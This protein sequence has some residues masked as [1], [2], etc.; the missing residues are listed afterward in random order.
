MHV[1]IL[2]AGLGTRLRPLSKRVPKP[3]IDICGKSLISKIIGTFKQIGLRDFTIIIGYESQSIR[4]EIQKMNDIN[5][6]FVNQDVQ[7]GMAEALFLCL[8]F[9]IEKDGIIPDFFLTASDVL[10]SP[11]R[12]KLMHD[13]FNSTHSDCIL[14][15]MK[16]YDEEIARGHGNVAIKKE[17]NK[18]P[19]LFTKNIRLITDIIE[20]PQPIQILSN[21]YSLPLYIFKHKIYE[22]L[23]NI[24]ISIRGEK[25]L[26]DA[27]KSIIK[28]QGSVY[29]INIIDE[30]ISQENIGKYHLT[31]LNDIKLM[32]FRFLRG[33]KIENALDTYPTILEPINLESDVSINEDVL[34]GP[35]VII[36]QNTLISNNCEISNSIIYESCNINPFCILNGCIV[37][38]DTQIPE[39][40]RIINK[41]I[42]F[43]DNKKLQLIDLL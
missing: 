15:L 7:G 39:G 23:K 13:L 1:I 14:S 17:K 33:I 21:Y 31:Y 20:K 40:M 24:K 2:A 18:T 12:L 32:N 29:G 42:Y 26:Q 25:E 9:L 5:V 22:Y 3:L 30:L 10:F 37:E 6:N 28:N 27:I 11:N 35:N 34:L 19:E 16:S 36:K 4:K 38:K 41:F 43:D 8:N